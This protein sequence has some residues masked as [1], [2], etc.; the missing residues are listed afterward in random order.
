MSVYKEA[1]YAVRELKPQQKRIYPDACDYGIPIKDFSDPAILAVQNLIAQYFS[2]EFDSRKEEQYE[3]GA[4][5]TVRMIMCD[6]F[7]SGEEFT[8]TVTLTTIK[9]GSRTRFGNIVGILEIDDQDVWAPSN[10]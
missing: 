1:M 8:L 3:T 7:G 6:E 5:V 2:P 4:T 9:G 10:F